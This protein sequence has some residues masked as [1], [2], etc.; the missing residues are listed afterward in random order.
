MTQPPPP[1]LTDAIRQ[2]VHAEDCEARGHMYVI[3]TMLQ[4]VQD[5]PV[6]HQVVQGPTDA[7]LPF[8]SCGRCDKVWLVMEDPGAS[9]A[10]AVTT[11][12]VKLKDPADA[13]PK[14]RPPVKAP[15]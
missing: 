15:K 11:L 14:K 7:Q 10:D 4:A 8:L 2:A 13:K 5:A 1:V 9:Y 3:S 6:M 12:A